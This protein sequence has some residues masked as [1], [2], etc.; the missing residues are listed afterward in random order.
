[1]SSTHNKQRICNPLQPVYFIKSWEKL[2]KCQAHF[3]EKLN[4]LKLR[5]NDGFRKKKVYPN[6]HNKNRSTMDRA[7][8][9]GGRGRSP[10]II[11]FHS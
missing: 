11:F 4:K 2:R 8:G 3:R 10:L 5:Q 7:R 1:M 6:D 9:L